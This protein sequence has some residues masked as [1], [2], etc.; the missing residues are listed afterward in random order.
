MKKSLFLLFIFS[1]LVFSSCEDT[2]T[3]TIH[4]TL[5]KDNLNGK[6]VYLQTM[7][8]DSLMSQK[9]PVVTDST[10]IKDGKFTFNIKRENDAPILAL[11]GTKAAPSDTSSFA[12]M[13]IVLEPGEIKIDINNKRITLGGTTKNEE[14]HTAFY[15]PMNQLFDIY[16]E[17]E[18][19]G[20]VD[21]VPLDQNG[22]DVG[23]RMKIMSRDFKK[24]MYKFVKDNISN[25][26]GEALFF[27]MGSSF[28]KQQMNELINLSNTTFQNRDIIKQTKEMIDFQ[29]EKEARIIGKQFSDLKLTNLKGSQEMLSKYIGKGKYAYLYFW[30]T[31]SEECFNLL[32]SL[33]DVNETY[34]NKDFVLV[35]VSL[36]QDK[37]MWKQ[38]MQVFNLPG[39]Q[40]IDSDFKSP[41]VYE[42][43]EIPYTLFIDKQGKIIAV[44][45]TAD[46]L[47]DRLEEVLK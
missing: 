31:Q 11:I 19:A 20:G 4:G 32:A 29:M 1:L 15:S 13:F 36:D 10:E 39:I 46:D 38:A 21:N 28:N 35:G 41:P 7:Q 24:E 25:E 18:K 30:N 6:K 5:N 26:A 45:I 2:P 9:E 27:T 40:L 37:E 43:D 14:L 33:L 12:D 23:K 47:E 44:N 22:N 16:D 34:G 17:I 3:A 42:F 8:I